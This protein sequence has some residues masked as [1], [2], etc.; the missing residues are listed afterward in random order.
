MAGAPVGGSAVYK[1]VPEIAEASGHGRRLGRDLACLHPRGR[2][3]AAPNQRLRPL[4]PGALLKNR[5]ASGP[6]ARPPARRGR[7]RPRRERGP[8]PDQGDARP[9]VDRDHL[10]HVHLAAPP[11]GPGHRRG[12]FAPRLAGWEPVVVLIGDGV[13]DTEPAAAR[14]SAHASLTQTAPDKVSEAE[15]TTRMAETAAHP[16][17]SR[18]PPVGLGPTTP[19]FKGPAQV[20]RPQRTKKAAD[21]RIHAGQQP[22][23]DATP[24]LRGGTPQVTPE[25]VVR[26]APK[27]CP[28]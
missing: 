18:E 28:L 3:L 1:E 25:L 4:L 24:A 19:A 20:Y 15:E 13:S 7:A 11:G 22:S 5:A 16:G 2:Q 12:H 10:G 14:P 6:P 21:L 26:Y 8:A 23:T 27:L 9:L 17:W